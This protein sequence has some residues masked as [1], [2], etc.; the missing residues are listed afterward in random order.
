MG[1]IAAKGL[2]AK[3][4]LGDVIRQ[5]AT[6]ASYPVM[7]SKAEELA[8]TIAHVERAGGLGFHSV[9]GN[10]FASMGV[11]IFRSDPKN[12]RNVLSRTFAPISYGSPITRKPL[13]KGEY[14]NLPYYYGGDAV[15]KRPYRATS[16]GGMLTG[17]E[18]ATKHRK[19]VR[20]AYTRTKRNLIGVYVYAT[21]PYTKEVNA[22]YG[23]ILSEALRILLRSI[24]SR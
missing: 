6:E 21:M 23:N 17:S 15:K 7:A 18:R 20:T 11:T 5:K 4:A 19:E 12:H 9:T 14:Y 1:L 13:R 8:Q 16:E 10:L 22:K 24:F 3:Q 2:I